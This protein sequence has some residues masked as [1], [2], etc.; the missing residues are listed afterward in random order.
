MEHRGPF[1]DP[2]PFVLGCCQVFTWPAFVL[3]RASTHNVS[4]T[5]HCGFDQ[6]LSGTMWA[7]WGC[8][9][10][11]WEQVARPKDCCIPQGAAES[12]HAGPCAHMAAQGGEVQR[13]QRALVLRLT[14]SFDLSE[15][16]HVRCEGQ[17]W[18]EKAVFSLLQV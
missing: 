7:F 6:A 5:E 3:A 12:H 4:G 9:L 14:N 13:R 11:S 15:A 1:H 8:L 16:A 2:D 18:E 10:W 17:P